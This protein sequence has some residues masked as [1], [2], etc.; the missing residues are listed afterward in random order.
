MKSAYELAMER[1]EKS[2][3]SVKLSDA[4][5]AEIA[6]LE[7]LYKSKIAEKEVFLGGEIAAA[8]AKGEFGEAE[9]H[10]LQLQREI[11][12][13]QEECEEKKERVRRAA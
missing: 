8:R 6:D 3:P 9:T 11:R 12:R 7:A 1:L 2:A 5:R 4:Q 10:Q 13:L